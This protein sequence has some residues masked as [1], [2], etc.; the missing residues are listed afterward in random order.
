MIAA[1]LIIFSIEIAAMRAIAQKYTRD[2][3]DLIEVEEFISRASLEDIVRMRHHSITSFIAFC[4]LSI[5]CAARL[6]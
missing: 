6:S 2:D 1:A 4:L 3:E 5:C